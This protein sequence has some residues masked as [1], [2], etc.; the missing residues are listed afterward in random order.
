MLIYNATI[1]ML[2]VSTPSPGTIALQ[3]L[4]PT[5][6]YTPAS[7]LKLPKDIG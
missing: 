5:C 7:S 2:G 1:Y 6:P 3:S 4:A